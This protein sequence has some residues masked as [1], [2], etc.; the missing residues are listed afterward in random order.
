MI[1]G[2]HVVDINLP[3][4]AILRGKL[5]SLDQVK[6]EITGELL[7]R[8]SRER[9]IFELVALLDY[10]AARG[11]EEAEFPALQEL[12]AALADVQRGVVPPML[13]VERAANRPETHLRRL[14]LE[15]A[16]VAATETLYLHSGGD[17]AKCTAWVAAHIRQRESGRNR[18]RSFARR[19]FSTSTRRRRRGPQMRMDRGRSTACLGIRGPEYGAKHRTSRTCGRHGVAAAS[20]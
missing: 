1:S 12:K 11:V 2:N 7:P 17:L 4:E 10:A 14:G 18:S 3:H 5:R 6:D 15:A 13:K 16:T 20:L 19:P 9:A 8:T